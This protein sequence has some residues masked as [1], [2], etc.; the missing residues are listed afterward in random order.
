MREILFRGKK[1][2]TNE[3]VNGSLISVCGKS[4]IEE[5]VRLSKSYEVN[6][7]TVCQYIGLKDKNGVRIFEGDIVKI[8]RKNTETGEINVYTGS[9]VFIEKA[10]LFAVN[11]KSETISFNLMFNNAGFYSYV[12]E[13]I[14]NI[15]DNKELLK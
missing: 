13:I 12:I 6:S 5:Q 7:D 14:G 2:G 11:T 1:T 9:V 10:L 4:Y 8:Y 15:H 3:W